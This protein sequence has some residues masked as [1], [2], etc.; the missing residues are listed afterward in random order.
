MSL[1]VGLDVTRLATGVWRAAIAVAVS[2]LIAVVVLL[3][4]AWAGH[5][6]FWVPALLAWLGVASCAAPASV[7]LIRRA[8]SGPAGE[9]DAETAG[10]AQRQV[11]LFRAARQDVLTGLQS[12]L[13]FLDTFASRLG[14]GG[15]VA[16]VLVDAD[17]FSRF[18]GLH[19]D[20]RGDEVLRVLADRLRS[21]AGQRDHAARLGSDE[22]AL[23]LDRPADVE[24]IKRTA[25]L[26]HQQLSEPYPAAGELLDVTVSL[27]IACAPQ[28]G[29]SVE[30]LYGAARFALQEA[31]KA[32]GNGWRLCGQDHAEVLRLR[33]RF[34]DV[35]SGAIDKGEIIPH[36]QP[37]V[38]LPEGGIARF[39]VLARWAHGKFGVLTPEQFIP[40]AEELG[41]TGRISMA[42]LRQVALDTEDWPQWCRLAINV[43]AG[44]LRELVGFFREQPGDW[45]RRMDLSRLDV[46][47]TEQALVRDRAMVSELISALHIHG[48]RAVLDNFGCGYSNLFHL[49]DM[50]FD[51]IKIGKGFV[52]TLLDDPRTEACVNAM[53]SLGQGLNIDMVADGVESHAIAERLSQ[54]GCNFAQ[55]F[56]YARPAPAADVRRLLHLPDP[57][58][59][60]SAVASA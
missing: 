14:V 37:I 40:L 15:T 6:G 22:F 30:T 42:L 48:A 27:G 31:K 38:R 36:Y 44:Q 59:A 4:Q 49:R 24:D 33:D 57:K 54:L 43:S 53:L 52:T 41:L 17:K 29:E 50:D 45:Q 8:A 51:S 34:R 12:R 16:L 47:I 11:E 35:L 9:A 26:L 1:P 7:W 3:R 21:A 18:N 23:V 5:A 58:P 19:G 46:E 20:G 28:H 32:G 56:L 13:G 2:G 55:G 10:L 39:E 60:Q 25:A